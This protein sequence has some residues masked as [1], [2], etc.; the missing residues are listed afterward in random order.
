MQRRSRAKMKKSIV[1]SEMNE[2][3]VDDLVVNELPPETKSY[4]EKIA[5]NLQIARIYAVRL[6][7]LTFDACGIYLFWIFV[8]YVSSHMYVYF[9]TP[10]TFIGFVLSPFIVAAQHCRALRWVMFNGSA[11]IDNMWIV[12]GTWLCAKLVV[13]R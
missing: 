13:P 10:N 11:S 4:Q 6:F 2:E 7:W 8:H 1:I 3:V 9:C 5:E 12:F